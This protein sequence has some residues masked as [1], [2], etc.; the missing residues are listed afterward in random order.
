VN[1][2]VI[3]GGLAGLSAAYFLAEAGHEV[4]LLE[5]T[6]RLGGQIQ[7]ELG[8][9]FVIEH[10]AE[11]FPAASE[12]VLDLC[13]RLGLAER[14]VE[15]R[16]RRIALWDDG[17]VVELDPARAAELIG[18]PTSGR[19]SRGLASFSGGMQDLVSALSARPP[20][21]AGRIAAHLDRAV[22]A[23]ERGPRGWIARASDHSDFT[24][25]ALIVATPPR[26]AAE[27]LQPIA[28]GAAALARAPVRSSLCVSL[29]VRY[30]QFGTT[31]D[32]GGVI[33]RDRSDRALV[34]AT[35]CSSR[36]PERAPAGW[37][38]L[39]VFFRPDPAELS[40]PDRFWVERAWRGLAP[41]FGLRG[42]AEKVRVSRWP[43][44]LPR[45]LTESALAGLDLPP[46]IGL[47]G[48]GGVEGAVGSAS[49]A[50][51]RLNGV[52]TGERPAASTGLGLSPQ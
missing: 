37:H 10:G 25:D 15:Q 45:P 22:R 18:I 5:A 11:G 19:S 48:G 32:L 13:R 4:T 40:I 24:A 23:I 52:G 27:L 12:P 1:V 38:L 8:D 46:T 43:N 39:R 9:G 7:T 17:A 42:S 35:V 49:A 50:A 36:F 14:L 26:I 34:A 51:E 30:G 41:V 2:V 3:G 31:R 21:G 28:P 33:L 6:G 20:H 44:A 16:D 29:A 47:A